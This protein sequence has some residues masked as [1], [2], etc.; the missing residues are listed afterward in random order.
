VTYDVGWSDDEIVEG[1]IMASH[2][3][4]TTTVVQALHLEEDLVT[5]E[6]TGY[7]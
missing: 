1:L 4:W 7:F 5:P 6:F 2:S 3:A